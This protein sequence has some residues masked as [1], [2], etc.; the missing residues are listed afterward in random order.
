[1]YIS[2]ANFSS[3]ES[4]TGSWSEWHKFVKHRPLSTRH[5]D[6]YSWVRRLHERW[7]VANEKMVFERNWLED[8][9]RSLREGLLV[10]LV[11]HSTLVH[12]A[13]RLNFS[14]Q[15]PWTVSSKQRLHLGP[16]D[17][18]DAVKRRQVRLVVSIR[19]QDLSWTQNIDALWAT[20]STVKLTLC[21]RGEII[22]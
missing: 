8:V 9:L 17:A 7:H 1:M 15:F 21:E 2:R 10:H 13:S 14:C 11:E 18:R 20:H 5:V 22:R 12:L 3:L 16:A 4:K 19:C 6:S